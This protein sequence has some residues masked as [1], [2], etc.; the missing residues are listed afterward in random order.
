MKLHDESAHIAS[1]LRLLNWLSVS[2]RYR[3]NEGISA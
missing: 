2:Y 1:K 3:E